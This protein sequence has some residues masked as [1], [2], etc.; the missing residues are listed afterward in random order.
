MMKISWELVGHSIWL[1]GSLV[2]RSM[3]PRSL[4]FSSPPGVSPFR[5]ITVTLTKHL[6]W[7]WQFRIILALSVSDVG[8]SFGI[9]ESKI[10]IPNLAS[11]SRVQCC[12]VTVRF[13]A[14]Q[15][16]GI[17][18]VDP[19]LS[20][21]RTLKWFRFIRFPVRRELP[22]DPNSIGPI[23]IRC[24]SSR[25]W[26]CSPSS[27]WLVRVR[28]SSHSSN[29][30][31]YALVHRLQTFAYKFRNILAHPRRERWRRWFNRPIN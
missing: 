10:W 13:S 4:S 12:C 8:A 22:A 2:S 1:F 18:S 7:H 6:D 30:S 25:D 31:K 23:G 27:L 11:V 17:Y 16:A 9:F 21:Y 3:Y 26:V 29:S 19:K 20:V 28:T 14:I 24:R 5:Q 15:S